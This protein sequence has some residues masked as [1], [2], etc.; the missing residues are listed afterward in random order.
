MRNDE[1]HDECCRS[2]EGEIDTTKAEV[3]ADPDLHRTYCQPGDKQYCEAHTDDTS[4]ERQLK[5]VVVRTIGVDV[6]QCILGFFKERV[7]RRESP[8]AGAKR[9]KSLGRGKGV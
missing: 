4:L 6:D 9:H 5:H 3:S 1:A 8:H 7:D 2:G